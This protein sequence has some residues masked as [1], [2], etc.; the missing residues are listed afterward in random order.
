MGVSVRIN[1]V[2][3]DTLYLTDQEYGKINSLQHQDWKKFW[4]SVSVKTYIR[5]TNLIDLVKVETQS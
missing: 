4:T 3:M 5:I 2:P 1:S